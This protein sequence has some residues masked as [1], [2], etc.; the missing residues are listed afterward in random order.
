MMRT[1][2]FVFLRL[3]RSS[4]SVV[5]QHILNMQFVCYA[6]RPLHDAKHSDCNSIDH[7]AISATISVEDRPDLVCALDTGEL[8]AKIVSFEIFLSLT[9]PSYFFFFFFNNPA[10]PE[11]SPLPQHAALPIWLALE[12]P[13]PGYG[14]RLPPLNQGG[15]WLLAGFFLTAAI[16]LWWVRM[17]RRARK[18]GMGTHVAWALDRKSTRLNSSHGYISYAVFCL[19]KKK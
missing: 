19:K 1:Q 7:P 17:Y 18:L 11:I 14:L 12:P 8:A 4:P 6:L 3:D 10:P 15:W 16:L 9:Q 2:Y 5:L 13:P